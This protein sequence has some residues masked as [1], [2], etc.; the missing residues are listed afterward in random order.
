MYPKIPRGLLIL[1]KNRIH[2]DEVTEEGHY[3][4]S[5]AAQINEWWND[6]RWENTK[7]IYKGKTIFIP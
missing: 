5:E 6:S 2:H 1:Q 4:S 3:L 7:R